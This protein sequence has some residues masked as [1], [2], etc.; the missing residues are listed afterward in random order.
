M[1]QELKKVLYETVVMDDGLLDRMK[2]DIES[3]ACPEEFRFVK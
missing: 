3:G 1:A 2:G